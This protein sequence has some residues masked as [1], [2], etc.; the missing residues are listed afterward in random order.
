LIAQYPDVS[1]YEI[2]QVPVGQDS[3]LLLDDT[4]HVCGI[5]TVGTDIFYAGAGVIFYLQDSE[6]GPFSGIMAYGQDS[7][8]IPSLVR[9]DSVCF[10]AIFSYFPWPD[11]SIPCYQLI[12]GSLEFISSGHPLPEAIVITAE[13]IDSTGNADSLAAQY[14]AC[15][16][17]INNVTV[18]S[19]ILYSNTSTWICHDTTSHQFIV[20]EASDSIDFVPIIGFPF[21]YI[22]GVI[23]HRFGVYNFQ[24]AYW[25]DFGYIGQLWH[26]P[27]QPGS[28]DTVYIFLV[29]P[30]YNEIVRADLRFRI[31]L[32][33]WMSVPFT[34]VYNS[35]Y[36][37]LFPPFTPGMRVAY[38]AE[39]EDTAGNIWMI[40]PDAPWNFYSFYVD[41]MQ[42]MDDEELYLPDRI[43]LYQNYP[44]P[45]NESTTITFALPEASFV[46]LKVFDMLG[47]E[48]AVLIEN[49]L[50]KGTHSVEFKDMNLAGGIY[51]YQIKAGDFTQTKRMILLK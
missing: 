36:E 22:K 19:V 21:R 47:R 20:R 35:L 8:L 14:D 17:R 27:E 15:L 25:N 50:A 6:G 45:F 39:L 43:R 10:D 30:E 42:D 34:Q 51:F 33:A 26:W 24:P 44:N 7:D 13:M 5:V 31:N 1:I 4:V 32:G 49:R 48:V 37:Y 12:P 23:Y 9:G 29:I 18:D 11:D 40:P 28:G 38:C 2:Q 46:T 16:V 41:E 3:T